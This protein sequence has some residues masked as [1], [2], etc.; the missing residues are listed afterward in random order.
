MSA[1]LAKNIRRLVSGSLT[2]DQN[3]VQ[4]KIRRIE[5]DRIYGFLKVGNDEKGENF[6]L[7]FQATSTARGA[8]LSLE[9]DGRNMK[10]D[11]RGKDSDFNSRKEIM[12]LKEIIASALTGDRTAQE[13]LKRAIASHE[14]TT[15][16]LK[17][18]IVRSAIGYALGI[19]R[20]RV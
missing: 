10:G 8:I 6:L 14:I 11:Q 16:Q 15:D 2:G 13:T 17:P 7:D 9:I 4:V 12:A 20:S 19:L 18:E 5:E 1:T 3:V